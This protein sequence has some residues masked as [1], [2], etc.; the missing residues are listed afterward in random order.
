[1]SSRLP[2]KVRI[3]PTVDLD[4]GGIAALA[5]S[6]HVTVVLFRFRL[7]KTRPAHLIAKL[8]SVFRVSV[9]ALQQPAVVEV[10]E[11]RHRVQ[12]PPIRET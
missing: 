3:L 4:V 1:L 5:R 12:P 11:C 10:E 7:H 2:A 9:P 6:R 8:K